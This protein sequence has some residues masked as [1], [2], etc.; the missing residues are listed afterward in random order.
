MMC[1]VGYVYIG[2]SLYSGYTASFL[3][4][5]F[6]VCCTVSTL[7]SVFVH[8]FSV[9]YR[10]LWVRLT[11]LIFRFWFWNFSSQSFT[12]LFIY[13]LLTRTHILSFTNKITF[14]EITFYKIYFLRLKI[15]LT[16][17]LFSWRR[18]VLCS[19]TSRKTGEH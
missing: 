7:L 16:S 4:V 15:M 12:S 2:S 6:T 17:K 3:V 13:F 19:S 18:S 9:Q 5:I 8:T 1:M 10:Q 11:I 14:H